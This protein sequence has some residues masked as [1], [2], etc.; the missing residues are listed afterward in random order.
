MQTL[1]LKLFASA[2]WCAIMFGVY[3]FLWWLVPQF[4]PWLTD[5]LF[6]VGGP[7]WLIATAVV[8]YRHRKRGGHLRY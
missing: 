1:P 2:L 4:P 6:F 3:K 5:L 7:L 8:L